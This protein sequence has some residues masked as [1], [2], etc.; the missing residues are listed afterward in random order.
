MNQTTQQEKK[1][2]WHTRIMELND[3]TVDGLRQQQ[4]LINRNPAT[5][6][7]ATRENPVQEVKRT[8]TNHVVVNKV[9]DGKPYYNFI[10]WYKEKPTSTAQVQNPP[11]MAQPQLIR[12]QTTTGI[13]LSRFHS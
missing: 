12:P 4:D 5:F 2:Y 11:P 6:V 10:I 8:E 7:I 9:V 13:P 3:A 1:E